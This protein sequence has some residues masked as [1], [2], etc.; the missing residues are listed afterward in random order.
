MGWFTSS[1]L[2]S[3]NNSEAWRESNPSLALEN[4]IYTSVWGGAAVRPAASQLQR[5]HQVYGGSWQGNH[6]NPILRLISPYSCS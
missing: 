1:L 3:S 5:L 6:I 4:Y 2:A